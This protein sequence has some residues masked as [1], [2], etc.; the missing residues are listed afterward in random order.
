MASSD[1]IPPSLEADFV[2]LRKLRDDD[3]SGALKDWLTQDSEDPREWKH[4]YGK[5]VTVEGGRVTD[6]SLRF[7]ESLAALPDAIGKLGISKSRG[8][9]RGRRDWGLGCHRRYEVRR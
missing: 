2:V 4:K 6:L 1:D 3:A 8:R 7:C 9:Q 5:V